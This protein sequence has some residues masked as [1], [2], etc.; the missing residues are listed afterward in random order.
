MV[1]RIAKMNR[2]DRIALAAVEKQMLS[3]SNAPLL[4]K[5][6]DTTGGLRGIITDGTGREVASRVG[7]AD[8]TE[9]K[10]WA[11]DFAKRRGET[12]VERVGGV[13]L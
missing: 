9:L 4:L 11:K 1:R 3:S 8:K 13:P 10:R 7:P 12:I 5:I 6:D 2:Q